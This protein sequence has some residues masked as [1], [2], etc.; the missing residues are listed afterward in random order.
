MH[1]EEAH[2]VC[3]LEMVALV[4]DMM[5]VMVQAGRLTVQKAKIK[6]NDFRIQYLRNKFMLRTMLNIIPMKLIYK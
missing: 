4:R 5:E 3:S 2:I 1:Q 6:T